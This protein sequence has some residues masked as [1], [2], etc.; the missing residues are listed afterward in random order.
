MQNFAKYLDDPARVVL[1]ARD[2]TRILGYAMLIRGG[3][4]DDPAV[5][6]AVTLRPAVELSKM[7]AL[8]TCTAPGG[9]PR[10]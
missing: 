8:P 1:I 9:S 3:V 7:Y 4:P 6:G 5:A 2:D 10:R